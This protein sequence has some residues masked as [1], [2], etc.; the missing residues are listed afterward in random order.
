MLTPLFSRLFGSRPKTI[1]GMIHVRALPGT[2]RH[3]GGI[4]PILDH[5][6]ADDGMIKLADLISL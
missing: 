6:L 2:P 5:A 1:I 3:S 4:A